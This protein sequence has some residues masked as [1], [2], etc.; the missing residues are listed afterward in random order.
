MFLEILK[1]G[2]LTIFFATAVIGIASIPDWIKIPEWYRKRIFIALIIEVIGVIIIYSK[3]E[4][5]IANDKSLPEITIEN[6]NWM[7][8]DEQGLIVKPEISVKTR[9]TTYIKQLGSASSLEIKG[10][11]GKVIEGGL[12]IQNADS[13]RIGYIKGLNLEQSGL[14]NAIETAKG[15][16]TS[17]ENYAY[18]KWKKTLDKPWEKKGEF[19]GPFKLEITDCNEGTYY[20]IKKNNQEC[21]FDSRNSSKDLISVDNRIIHFYE[22]QN[23]Y[24]LLRIAWADLKQ[25][26]KYVHIINVRIEP[27][28]KQKI[29]ETSRIA[30][31]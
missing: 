20:Q 27:T 31:R 22:H 25:E 7:A 12:S 18:I 9:D 28:F 26:D 13:I 4:F 14:F 5:K 17:T 30:S 29:T 8:V 11:N 1:Y 15:E 24:Y 10:L 3:Q 6:N 2:F 23:V 16:I 19:I 21:L